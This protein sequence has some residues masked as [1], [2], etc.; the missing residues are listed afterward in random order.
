M[1]DGGSNTFFPLLFY[2]LF[3]LFYLLILSSTLLSF[4]N[5]LHRFLNLRAEKNV[6]AAIERREYFIGASKKPTESTTMMEPPND[7]LGF[8]TI[9]T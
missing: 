3:T 6:F 2:H 9:Y 7:Y 5:S 4:C 8:C 1:A